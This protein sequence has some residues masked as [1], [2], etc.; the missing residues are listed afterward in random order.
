M[1]SCS[2]GDVKCQVEVCPQRLVCSKNERLVHLPGDCCP[3]CQENDGECSL[4]SS[5]LPSTSMS[6]KTFDGHVFPFNGLCNYVLARDSS[7]KK[8]FSIHI[9]HDF[10]GTSRTITS[11]LD[12]MAIVVKVEQL[13]V[14]LIRVSGPEMWKIRVGRSEAPLPFIKLG[15][16]SVIKYSSSLQ[17]RSSNLGD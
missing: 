12:S 13:K 9:I 1:C 5:L 11:T 8:K 6:L 4:T 15:I 2:G 3:S 7:E 17:V 14:R 16:L 10:N